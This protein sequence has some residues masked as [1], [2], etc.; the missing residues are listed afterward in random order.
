MIDVLG[1]VDRAVGI[2]KK[3]YAISE[4]IKD[5]DVR[6]AISDLRIAMADLKDQVVELRDKNQRLEAELSAV[7]KLTSGSEVE[8]REG[9]YYLREP[10]GRPAGPYCTACWDTKHVLALASELPMGFRDLGR[11]TCPACQAVFGA[12]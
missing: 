3:L 7:K 12:S 5:A 2:A 4:K 10:G 8:L 9:A 1:T 11:Y 6:N